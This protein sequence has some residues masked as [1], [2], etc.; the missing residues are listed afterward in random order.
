ME[1]LHY[2]TRPYDG[3]PDGETVSFEVVCR[4]CGHKWH[5]VY[6][7]IEKGML[8]DVEKQDYVPCP[9]GGD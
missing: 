7:R 8:W 9:K 3:G 1:D 2:S 5:E 6:C 4:I